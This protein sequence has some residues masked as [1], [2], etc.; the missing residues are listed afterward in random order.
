MGSGRES[1]LLAA[2]VVG[3][4]L[5]LEEEPPPLPEPFLEDEEPDLDLDLEGL[6]SSF[7]LNLPPSVVAV[8]AFE[9]DSSPAGPCG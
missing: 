1:G 4:D 5:C 7:D 8:V 6:A 3:I 9:E 2:V